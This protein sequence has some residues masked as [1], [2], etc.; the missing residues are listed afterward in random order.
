R[1]GYKWLV[2]IGGVFFLIGQLLLSFLTPTTSVFY[3][4][5]LMFILGLGFGLTMTAI[6]IAVQSS[7][8]WRQRGVATS[9]V[10]FMRTMGQTVGITMFGAVFNM[11]LLQGHMETGLV[12]VFHALFVTAIIGMFV[13]IFLPKKAEQ[14]EEE[15]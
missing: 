14:V 2:A 3:I 5:F 8:V 12:K 9:S 4:G 7:V 15:H 6:T 1:L 13:T 10:Q 11:Y